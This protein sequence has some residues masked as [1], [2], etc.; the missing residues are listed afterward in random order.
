MTLLTIDQIQQRAY[1]LDI[2][3]YSNQIN[4]TNKI[5][6]PRIDEIKSKILF[7]RAEI[8]REFEEQKKT[9][10]SFEYG[11][12]DINHYPIGFCRQIRDKVFE[13]LQ[14][15]TLFTEFVNNGIIL[16]EIYIILRDKYFQNA[17]QLGNL[18]IDIANDTVA[19]NESKLEICELN[20]FD[21]KNLDDY[22]EYFKVAEKYLHIALYPNNFFPFFTAI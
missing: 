12:I 3:N 14:K 9:K 19:I 4:I 21:F 11:I 1:L 10:T 2:Q 5:V 15:D 13:K 20:N 8:D 22:D 17:I 7:Y 16:K 6:I 18:Y